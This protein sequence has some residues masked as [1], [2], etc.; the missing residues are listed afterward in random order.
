MAKIAATI[1][2]SVQ[3]GKRID[4]ISIDPLLVALSQNDLYE[5]RKLAI[6]FT[7]IILTNQVKEALINKRPLM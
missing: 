1:K 6:G 5:L 3:Y 2:K 7:L 4:E